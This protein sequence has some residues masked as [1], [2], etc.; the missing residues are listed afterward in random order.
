MSGITLPVLIEVVRGTTV[1]SRHRGAA[2]V[3]DRHGKVVWSLGDSELVM[4]PR[5]AI[6]PIQAALVM[7]ESGA[8]AAFGVSR[9][10][11]ALACSSHNGQPMHVEPVLAWL[12]RLGL[13]PTD[14]ECGRQDPG[15]ASD[16]H[17]LYRAGGEAGPEHNNCSGKHSGFLTICRHMGV[18][19]KG[20]LDPEHPT[21]AAVC[22]TMAEMCGVDL[23]RAD[24]GT[25]G[26]GVPS[27]AMPLHALAL[28]MAR[29]AD[30]A[31]LADARA[32]A[33]RAIVEAMAAHPL[34][35]AGTDRACSA[36]L[37][38]GR[39]RYVVKGGAEG[40]YAG[41]WP[42]KGYG[43]ALKIEDGAGRAAE[44]AMTHILRRIGALDDEAW[45]GLSEWATRPQRNWVGTRTGE[46]R[47]T[48]A[49]L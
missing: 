8:M 10:E 31:A 14:L 39:G 26:C 9:K 41:A 38:S 3:M 48:N 4:F 12:D 37:E 22:R 42:E 24:L 15:L 46:I 21:Q 13:S 2:V 34:M 33:C 6:K 5:S 27:I 44:I 19:P 17:A 25:D 1:E 35:V 29:L 11:L 47:A 36:L 28:G 49:L 18:D 43:I 40:V 32:Q 30:P 23:A 7:A 16:M 20:Y 45:S